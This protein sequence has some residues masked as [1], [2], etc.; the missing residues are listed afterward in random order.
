MVEG[1][2]REINQQRQP[3][4][5]AP[6][7]VTLSEPAQKR[8]LLILKSRLPVLT[9]AEV[10]GAWTFNPN[11]PELITGLDETRNVTMQIA[12]N[13]GEEIDPL[14]AL[15]MGLTPLVPQGQLEQW[16]NMDAKEPWDQEIKN[17]AQYFLS[18]NPPE[19][20]P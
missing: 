18:K 4:T 6:L 5:V 14:S 19:A 16:A 1:Q 2:P 3:E 17:K 9:K 13:L 8:V 10:S 12:K 7:T 11:R 15:E 20:K